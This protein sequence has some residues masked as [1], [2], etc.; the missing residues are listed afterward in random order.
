M[1]PLSLRRLRDEEVV[2]DPLPPLPPHRRDYLKGVLR[3][4]D[5]L[6]DWLG[7]S[8]HRASACM[9]EGCSRVLEEKLGGDIS[10]SQSSG[11]SMENSDVATLHRY[12]HGDSL[13]GDLHGDHAH[14]DNLLGGPH[15][16]SGES[17]MRLVTSE[18]LR[19]RPFERSPPPEMNHDDPNP[20][21]LETPST[22]GTTATDVTSS[23]SSTT[24]TA[25]RLPVGHRSSSVAPH[26]RLLRRTATAAEPFGSMWAGCEDYHGISVPWAVMFILTSTALMLYQIIWLQISKCG[27]RCHIPSLPLRPLL[28][29]ILCCYHGSNSFKVLSMQLDQ[30]LPHSLSDPFHWSLQPILVGPYYLILLRAAYKAGL[31]PTWATSSVDAVLQRCPPRVVE[32][33]DVAWGPYAGLMMHLNR[34]K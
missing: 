5:A 11:G 15:G 20:S 9:M 2:E 33:L 28:R 34:L 12:T 16:G 18:S 24:T 4:S 10:D 32:I 25:G 27:V 22:D 7:R 19:Q 3:I 14:G 21:P 13:H 30:I 26:E 8:G 31:L 29:I 17:E 6:A 23:D 1:D